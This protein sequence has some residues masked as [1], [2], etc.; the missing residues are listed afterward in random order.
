MN[1]IKKLIVP[2]LT[3]II[4][5]LGSS[6]RAQ[7]DIQVITQV[8]PPYSP[9]FSDY[10]SYENRLVI[11]LNNT[12][13]ETKE[14]R[15]TA[16]IIG[17]NG[18]SLQLQ[19][20]FIPPTPTLVP[21]FGNTRLTGIQLKDYW[22]IN[23]WLVSGVSA[24]DIIIGNGLPEGNYELCIQA[25]DYTTGMPLS[26]AAPSG[27]SFFNINSIEPPIILQPS[28]GVTVPSDAPQN[29]FFSWSIPAGTIPSQLEYELVIMELFN[30][31]DPNQVFLSSGTPPFFQKRIPVNVYNY[32][33]NDPPL[34]KGRK[35]AFRVTAL[36]RLGNPRPYNFRNGGS[37]EVCTFIYGGNDTD[38]ITIIDP[39]NN[40]QTIE[41]ELIVN[42]DD[43]LD[44]NQQ[45][46]NNANCIGS[47]INEIP[48]NATP[49]SNLSS[50]ESI[51][52][53][54][55]SLE[56][57][58]AQPSGNGF[59]GTG[60]ILVSF[61][62][63]PILV[64]FNQLKVNTNREVYEGNA[65]AKA[66]A[67]FFNNIDV[68]TQE[69]G[70]PQ[71]DVPLYK[72]IINFIENENQKVHLL[73]GT[74][75]PI[76]MPLSW[77]NGTNKITLLGIIF[78]AEK[79]HINLASG[80]ELI[81]SN[82]P[83]NFLILTGSNCMQANGF[84]NEGSLSLQNAV[85]IPISS[86]LSHEFKP[87][88]KINYDCNGISN[89]HLEGRLIFNRNSALPLD[90]NGNVVDGNVSANYSTDINNFYDWTIEI[91]K[92]SHPFTIPGL[93]G[94]Q[95]NSNNL[96]IDQSSSGTPP[97]TGKNELWQGIYV[98]N[99]NVRLPEFFNIDDEAI[100]KEIENFILD[101]DG[102]T[103]IIGPF[104]NL[105]TLEEGSVGGWPL[106]VDQ[107]SIDIENS[108]LNGVTISGGLQLPISETNLEYTAMITQGENPEDPFLMEFEVANE[109]TLEIPMWFAQIQLEE[110]STIVIEKVGNSWIPSA[111][112]HGNI[113]VGWN[114]N[115]APNLDNLVASFQLPEVT[116]TNLNITPGQNNIPN[117]K[118]G[119]FGLINAEASIANFNFG[120]N[121]PKG[122]SVQK[123][124]NGDLGLTFDIY[125][126]LGQEH[127]EI[128]GST[129][130]T[131]WGTLENNSY[132]YKSTQLEAIGISAD[133]NVATINGNLH[134]FGKDAIYGDGFKGAVEVELNQMEMGFGALFQV[135]AV[136]DDQEEIY[137]YFYSDSYAKIGGSGIWIPP[138]PFAVFGGSGGFWLNMK[139]AN[140]NQNVAQKTLED[141]KLELALDEQQAIALK[142]GTTRFDSDQKIP[143]KGGVGF[144][145]SIVIGIN[146]AE[147]LFNA[148]LGHGIEMN[149]D[150]SYG[151][152]TMD[153]KGYV[154]QELENARG[155]AFIQG[156]V[157]LTIGFLEGND[158]KTNIFF[159][160]TSTLNINILDGLVTGEGTLH[161]YADKHTWFHKLGYWENE[162]EPWLDT[163]PRVGLSLGEFEGLDNQLNNNDFNSSVHSYFMFGPEI[164]G[165]PQLPLAIRDNN[166]QNYQM[167][168]ERNQ[169]FKGPNSSH[170]V[171]MGG[172]LH[173]DTDLEFLIF[174]LKAK[175]IT[176]FDFALQKENGLCAGDFGLNGWYAKGQAYGYFYG[177]AG[178]ELDLW[179]WD[180]SQKIS[181]MELEAV[182]Q[183]NAGLPNP[184]YLN[185]D[186]ALKGSVL[187]GIIEFDLD[188][189]VELGEDC[190]N[191]NS[192]PFDEYPIIA[193]VIPED[194]AEKVHLFNQMEVS[195]NFPNEPFQYTEK[196]SEG[197]EVTR[198]FMYELD[199]FT[200]DWSDSEG[201]KSKQFIA[202]YRNDGYSA[203]F[204]NKDFVFS[205]ETTYTLAIGVTG[206]ELVEGKKEQRTTE[207]KTVTFTTDKMPTK[208]QEP[209]ILMSTPFIGENYF[210]PSHFQKGS[211]VLP[212][213]SP[214]WTNPNWWYTEGFELGD[215]YKGP[216]A[217]GSFE[218]IARF[219]DV[220]S[221]SVYDSPYQINNSNA[222][223]QWGGSLEFS[224][225]GG[226]EPDKIY[227][228][229]LLVVY[230]P[231]INN[232]APASN[233]QVEYQEVL[234]G[235]AG[236]GN[237]GGGINAGEGWQVLQGNLNFQNNGNGN[238]WIQPNIQPNPKPN[239]IFV[240]SLANANSGN[241]NISIKRQHRALLG[242][243][244]T[245]NKVEWPIFEG[246]KFH[247]KTSKYNT[248]AQK[249]GNITYATTKTVD[250]PMNVSAIENEGF[251]D[252]LNIKLPVAVLTC[253][254]NFDEKTVAT[255]IS[256]KY[257]TVTKPPLIEMSDQALYK[258]SYW[259]V[260]DPYD[261]NRENLWGA[262]PGN[263]TSALIATYHFPR[264]DSD[265]K[266]RLESNA[267]DYPSMDYWSQLLPSRTNNNI[268]GTIRYTGDQSSLYEP[269]NDRHY[270]NVY[271]AI[272]G[273]KTQPLYA[274]YHQD[275]QL[276]PMN[277]N[278]KKVG[279][280][281]KK[282]EYNTS[283]NN[284]GQIWGGNNQLQ[285][286]NPSNQDAFFGILDYTE[287][288]AVQ[289]WFR[290]RQYLFKRTLE[291]DNS[292]VPENETFIQVRAGLQQFILQEMPYWRQRRSGASPE[293]SIQ[294]YGGG[295]KTP[296][297]YNVPPNLNNN[298][299]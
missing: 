251:F 16:S 250:Y 221:K 269:F 241:Q 113:S 174:Y 72:D 220:K 78:S 142:P 146:S 114:E 158:D 59:S 63:I 125:A 36:N 116:F 170:G 229:Q 58:Q 243:T 53:G 8:L 105:I 118:F 115:N 132:T 169:V 161:L 5:V 217:D 134:F 108:N 10:V 127:F 284:G 60:K 147:T 270:P 227:E 86:L 101:K 171:A 1:T 259:G 143:E 297:T 70:I 51:T 162:N 236:Q 37:S 244:K 109:E 137:H 175:H 56:I 89:I 41:V 40:N 176:G 200:L 17:N 202:D 3:L 117:I 296:F 159:D 233:T 204:F 112:L 47:C 295:T 15:L 166:N 52:I 224:I 18:V 278:G 49:I 13:S 183:M 120:L 68:L 277:H 104:N 189:E 184:I 29:L 193:E 212:I 121:E 294:K 289:D 247:F 274:F 98:E 245:S 196:N 82:D 254:E 106:S 154:V 248:L 145:N 79:T 54:S 100:E 123:T 124:P 290:L 246:F 44:N 75:Q 9:Y 90:E 222:Q 195:F 205:P 46:N 234:L 276:A 282:L 141:L 185:G 292:D 228:L 138:T 160:N 30:D 65:Y 22:D 85:E 167:S 190:Q 283:N 135:G 62:D 91:P 97:N 102:V 223:G 192:G 199:F 291:I 181:F 164:P 28:S 232:V 67:P 48:Q 6:I 214:H 33:L 285:N 299:E 152:I 201:G 173:I 206:Y 38:P 272:A 226:L 45:Q 265:W 66:D 156:D 153:G 198:S 264:D 218:F 74:N 25:L 128:G 84:G 35:Y 92:L 281:T 267:Y 111:N 249:L 131:I 257:V 194:K 149:L 260:D 61:L 27:C 210:I 178:V 12:T 256:T 43:V 140:P 177:D 110:G 50:G 136:K 238:N 107:F 144:D 76:G 231:P 155:E 2:F 4:I 242:T 34:E 293:F 57:I 42:E 287:W 99:I 163:P 94:F 286:P 73:S 69:I 280:T 172:G 148:D 187:D 266:M 239:P 188:F 225:P 253:D 263:T 14:V 209:F 179:V 139:K 23:A 268:W 211:I 126:H 219:I 150:G 95:L 11:Q 130:F 203:V 216:L 55:F 133:L 151:S 64:E 275:Y 80:F 261:P 252:F 258:N 7:N 21:P 237:N 207:I 298:I 197:K 215:S 96:V 213:V 165:L 180:K 26:P 39:G 273:N 122:I 168:N 19:P 31:M 32:M 93:V 88:T 279:F 240:A 157:N 191:S 186:V 182:A 262:S 271:E 230:T 208:I 81:H 235:G 103:G 20:S 288:L 119:E 87:N 255:Q 83:N 24:S 77:E 129:L 71:I